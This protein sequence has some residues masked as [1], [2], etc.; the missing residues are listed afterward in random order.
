MSPNAPAPLPGVP[1]ARAKQ[2]GEV[3]ARWAWTE[4]SV[5][6]PRMLTALENGVKGGVWHSLIDKVY[7][8][9]NLAAAWQKVQANGGAAGV[10]RQSIRHFAAHAEQHLDRLAEE[11]RTNTY[12]PLA[13]RRTYIPKPGSTEKRPLGIPAVC[14]RVVQ[15]ALRHVLEPIFE[16]EFAHSSYGFRPQRTAREALRHVNHLLRQG[17]V[18]VVDADLQRC[19]DSIPHAG[20]LARIRERVADG[21]VLELVAQFLQ[22]DVL[23]GLDC[24]TPI[25]GTPQGGVISPLLA[26]IYLHG[27]DQHLAQHGLALV[28]YADDFV[29]LCRTEGEARRALHVIERWTTAAGLTLHPTKTRLVDMGQARASFEFL[30]Y[31]FYRTQDGRLSHWAR[32]KSVRKLKDTLRRHTPRNSGRSL[33]EIIRR[34]NAVLRGWFGY[35]QHSNAHTFPP[36]DTWLRMRLRS[37]LRRRRGRKGRGR[38]RDHHRW[39][40]AYFAAQGLYSLVAAHAAARQSV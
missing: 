19:F 17:Q 20:L 12:R 15:G 32:D 30:G 37:I 26:N 6:T 31:C 2:G 34:V 8:R 35:F 39:P 24:W 25:T 23:D 1:E 38:G 18:W 4:G 13:L 28:R 33:P 16:R 14:D 40:N 3:R 5:W 29:V 11:L 27:L 21:R 10:D 36:V 7:C 9:A 22:A